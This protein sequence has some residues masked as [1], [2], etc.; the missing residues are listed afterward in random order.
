MRVKLQTNHNLMMLFVMDKIRV[1]CEGE[2]F[3]P[4][5]GKVQSPLLIATYCAIIGLLVL[6]AG[7]FV[8]PLFS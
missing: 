6:C 8:S 1:L 5:E 7:I 4:P 2:L 3:L